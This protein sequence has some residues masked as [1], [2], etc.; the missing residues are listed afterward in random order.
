MKFS[1]A[2][3][4]DL[5][6]I[7]FTQDKIELGIRDYSILLFIVVYANVLC[8]CIIDAV[9]FAVVQPMANTAD[10]PW[11]RGSVTSS[12]SRRYPV[13]FTSGSAPMYDVSTLRRKSLDR[14]R[15]LRIGCHYQTNLLCSFVY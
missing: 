10:V 7:Q 12:P 2:D 11:H 8:M 15:K 6:P 1:V 13:G 14:R 3:S 4:L 5:L 9:T